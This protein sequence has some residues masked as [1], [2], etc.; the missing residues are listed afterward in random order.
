[1]DVKLIDL[2]ECLWHKNLFIW[3]TPRNSNKILIFTCRVLLEMCTIFIDCGV[4]WL[5]FFIFPKKYTIF[6][7]NILSCFTITRDQTNFFYVVS[8]N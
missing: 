5:I 2:R 4:S 6:F 7:L 3:V 1:M 8:H